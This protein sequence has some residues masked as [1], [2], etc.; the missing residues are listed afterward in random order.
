MGSLFGSGL[1]S[2]EGAD[3]LAGSCGG[4]RGGGGRGSW[5]VLALGA[6]RVG[7]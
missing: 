3:R 2:R 7:L 5:G 6:H 1:D 4:C